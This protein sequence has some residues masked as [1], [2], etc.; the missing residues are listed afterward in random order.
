MSKFIVVRDERLCKWCLACMAKCKKMNQLQ[1]KVR[2][3]VPSDATPLRDGLKQLA[4]MTCHHCATPL[5][6]EACPRGAIHRTQDGVVLVDEDKCD[7]CA[8]CVDA[9]PWHVPVVPEGGPMVK[10]TLCDGRAANGELPE[11]V[12]A[13]RQDALKLVRADEA[14]EEGFKKSGLTKILLDQS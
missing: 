8:A 12:K 4:V 7:G 1:D 14:A 6:L 10:C 3:T 9:C 2:M 5:C 13:C 11:C